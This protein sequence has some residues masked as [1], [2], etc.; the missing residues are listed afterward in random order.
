MPKQYA[1]DHTTELEKA[2]ARWEHIIQNGA[3][4]PGWPDGVNLN[5]VRNHILYHRRKLE[6]N[7]TLF[8]FPEVYYR[9]LPPEVDPDFMARPDEIRAAARASLE[10]YRAD[11]DYQFILAH[12]D[13]IPPKMRE[14]MCVGA[15]LGYV[16]RLERA[17]AEGD[18]VTQRRHRNAETYRS[19]LESCAQRIRNF[20]SVG[21]EFVDTQAFDE[22]EDEDFDEEF[23]EGYDE[24]F[25][26]ESDETLDMTLQM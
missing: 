17:I 24:N 19:S 25:D 6:E 16:A 18:L 1:P 14:K 9:E 3:G 5:L 20:L 22:P 11:P 12:R 2:F 15:V 10:V 4:D 8:G 23:D 26:A 7:P 21:T 13:E